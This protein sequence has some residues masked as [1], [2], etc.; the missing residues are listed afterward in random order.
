MR[1]LVRKHI[2]KRSYPYEKAK[3]IN[4]LIL[5]GGKYIFWPVVVRTHFWFLLSLSGVVICCIE[6]TKVTPCLEN[7]AIQCMLGGNST[8]SDT[9]ISWISWMVPGCLSL[10]VFPPTLCPSF[11]F[12]SFPPSSLPPL[13]P[14][15][16]IFFPHSSSSSKWHHVTS[17]P[18]KWHLIVT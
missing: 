16:F 1:T 4:K 5:Y 7:M 2:L 11:P 3:S 14:S 6:G 13:L 18:S 17:F 10:W 9:R 8:L 12:P 15:S